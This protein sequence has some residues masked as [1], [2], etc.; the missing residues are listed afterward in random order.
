MSRPDAST[1]LIEA[2]RATKP[3]QLKEPASKDPPKMVHT[4]LDSTW[5]ICSQY[6]CV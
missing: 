2:Y 3:A 5:L 1:W 4:Q 6:G